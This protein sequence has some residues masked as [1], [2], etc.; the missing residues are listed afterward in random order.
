MK[1]PTPLVYSESARLYVFIADYVQAQSGGMGRL[2]VSFMFLCYVM[3]SGYNIQQRT[4]VGFTLLQN[5]R[6][7]NI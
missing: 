5:G 4:K 3:V 2:T 1:G 7:W 6:Q